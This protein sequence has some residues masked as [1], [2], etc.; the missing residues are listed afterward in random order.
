MNI[1]PKPLPEP[2]ALK[3]RLMA[4]SAL[5]IILCPE[6]WLRRYRFDPKWGEDAALASIDNGAG[7]DM[8]I[9]FAPEGV[10]IKGF[11]H[12][13]DMSPHARDD[14]EVW[15]GIY[16]QTPDSLLKQLD[17]EA[18]NKENVTFCIWRV[19]GDSA[20]RTGDVD[21]QQGLDD[22]S[23]FLLGMI[24]DTLDDYVEWAESYY[25]MKISNDIVGQIYSGGKISVDM[26]K[27]MNASRDVE[28][29]MGELRQI[30]IATE[31]DS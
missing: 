11:D 4:L 31:V 12:E 21:N 26:V 13:S 5:D 2:E 16:E 29:A 14:D 17:D 23:D 15:P 27:K 6:E 9:V 7:D 8:F 3:R 10:I 22:G 18:L 20:W 24:Y 1:W 19:S 28:S 30:G 25:E